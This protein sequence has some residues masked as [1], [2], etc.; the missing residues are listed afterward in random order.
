MR[1]KIFSLL[2]LIIICVGAQNPQHNDSILRKL[3]DLVKRSLEE[4]FSGL[5]R[6]N[7]CL[8]KGKIEIINKSTIKYD[9]EI[10]FVYTDEK[11]KQIFEKG[12]FFPSLIT[13]QV[14]TGK[15]R[16]EELKTMLQRN[17]SITISNFVEKEKYYNTPDKREFSFLVFYKRHL[18]PTEYNITLT[19]K[20]INVETDLETFLNGAIATKIKYITLWI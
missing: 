3:N 13:G 5:E 17:D 1:A 9:D 7:D 15:E 16:E 11:Y 4:Q 2:M 6:N 18:N 19:N 8:F 12:I 14:K 20:N 10:M